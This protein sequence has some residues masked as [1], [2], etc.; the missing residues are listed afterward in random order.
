MVNSR[1]GCPN[2]KELN[3]EFVVLF[4]KTWEAIS[5]IDPAVLSEY[6][7]VHLQTLLSPLPNEVSED[8]Q[9]SVSSLTSLQD[10]LNV[11]TP[12]VSWYNYAIVQD[13]AC[14]LLSSD[15]HLLVL[16]RTYREKVKDYSMVELGQCG[17]VAYG[18]KG[19][20][21]TSLVVKLHPVYQSHPLHFVHHIWATVSSALG[22]PHCPCVYQC[23]N[24]NKSEAVF[25]VPTLVYNVAFPLNESQRLLLESAGLLKI[26]CGE[27]KYQLIDYKV[28]R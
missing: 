25:T 23:G 2:V 19:E 17:E 6:L 7:S 8:L 26:E 12:F 22:H 14:M 13:L 16:W 21:M 5:G 11:L 18:S 24:P 10:V 4:K 15:I 28:T 3:E 20:G 27:Y 1:S 9:E